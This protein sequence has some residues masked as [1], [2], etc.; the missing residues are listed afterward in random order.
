MVKRFDSV[1]FC[2]FKIFVA[3]TTVAYGIERITNLVG[4]LLGVK[5]GDGR[6]HRGDFC[7]R[8]QKLGLGCLFSQGPRHL[9]EI[10]CVTAA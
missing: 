7:T 4:A 3:H 1:H 2:S 10:Y 8:S 5:K 6:W 9:L